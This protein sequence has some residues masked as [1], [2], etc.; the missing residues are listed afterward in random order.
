MNPVFQTRFGGS[1][2]PRAEQ[3]NCMAACLASIFEIRLGAV[4]D[5]DISELVDGEGYLKQLQAWLRPKG[6]WCVSLDLD[7]QDWRPLGWAMVGVNSEALDTERTGDGHIVVA[8]DG[9]I[10][11]DPNPKS[12]KGPRDYKTREWWVFVK[13]DPRTP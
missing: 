6:L 12:Q 9:E 5:F 4:P 7:G 10:V 2:A 11:H 3:G 1:K 13:L 8:Y